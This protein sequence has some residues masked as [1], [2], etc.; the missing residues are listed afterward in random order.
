V[1]GYVERGELFPL[2]AQEFELREIRQAQEAFLEKNHI[3]KI[4]IRVAY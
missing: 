4:V 1:I 2:I 3:G